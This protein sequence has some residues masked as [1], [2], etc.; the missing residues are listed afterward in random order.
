MK[1][2]LLFF[3]IIPFNLVWASTH[4][5][6]IVKIENKADIYIPG[7][8]KDSIHKHVKY[9]DGVYHIVPA[10]LGAKLE[11]GTILSTGKNSKVKVIFVNGDHIFVSPNTQYKISWNVDPSSGKEDP[12]MI[13]LVRGAFRGIIRKD[14]P[15]SGMKVKSQTVAMGVRG[16][17]FYVSEK[18]G[19]FDVSVLRG[20]VEV[21]SLETKKVEKVKTGEALVVQDNS[22]KINVITK[23]DLKE[24]KATST[25]KSN[26]SPEF[27]DLEKKATEVVLGDI[28]E[29]QPAVYKELVENKKDTLSDSDT[30]AITTAQML[31]AKAPSKKLKATKDD[32][33][34]EVDPY[35]TYKFKNED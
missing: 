10:S 24:I 22:S 29:Y 21:T 12:S 25:L 11:N 16:T 23:E 19:S 20:E 33:D 27:K 1:L 2:L 28:K 31:E 9:L 18:H 26:P 35:D 5:A 15:R 6:R 13:N 34:K 14:G 8:T 30:I 17:D 4:V 3:L 32:L 7:E